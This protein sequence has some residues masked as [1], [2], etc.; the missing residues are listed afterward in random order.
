MPRSRVALLHAMATPASIC[1]HPT[2][3][4][5]RC[6]FLSSV[7]GAPRCCWCSVHCRSGIRWDRGGR[8]ISGFSGRDARGRVFCG[9]VL[10]ATN[11]I[12]H[13][14]RAPRGS[15]LHG[16]GAGAASRRR[17]PDGEIRTRRA[18]SGGA[19]LLAPAWQ[20]AWPAPGAVGN[21]PLV[22]ADLVATDGLPARYAYFTGCKSPRP[23]MIP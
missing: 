18:G 10:L 14:W 17:W 23:C 20:A 6:T 8:A 1:I 4:T 2:I 16:G 9:G 15:S 12:S 13:I 11:S 7:P 22:R 5:S 3:I 21:S 19:S